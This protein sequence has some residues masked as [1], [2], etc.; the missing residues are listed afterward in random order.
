MTSEMTSP[1]ASSVV[2][3]LSTDQAAALRI[4]DLVSE[5]FDAQD[6]A[7]GASETQAGWSVAIHFR[8]PP[9]ETAVRA[10]VALAAGAATANAL[11]FETV[12][13][14][15]WIAESH[16]ALAPVHAGRFVV[17]GA[18]DRD[19]VRNNR[20]GIE[21]EAA[22]AFGTGHH[23]T[24]RACLLA[25]DR[26]LR[27]RRPLNVLD[28]GTGSGVLAI[29]AGR[30]CRGRVLATDID[31]VAVRAARAN[32]HR[33]RAGHCVSVMRAA[34]MTG[35]SFQARRPFDLVFANI[36][37]EPLR[38][39]AAPLARLIAPRG[40]IVLSGLL[41]REANA[42]IAAYRAQGLALDRRIDLDGWT[43]LVFVR[44]A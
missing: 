30:A 41:A 33:N 8:E 44:N 14:A 21:I 38:R 34:G 19:R 36:L 39:V 25:L 32:A 27:A 35:K 22:L 6:V 7:A 23:G 31:P 24:T 5:S 42:A 3:R 29:A 9:N 17:H 16:R 10:L 11:R 37:L 28:L 4:T 1:A 12:A 18:H 43:T 26:I 20:I 15:D 40:C 13:A 2:A